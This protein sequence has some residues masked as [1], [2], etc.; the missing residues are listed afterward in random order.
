MPR[1]GELE[2][3]AP[4]TTC[5]GAFLTKRTF[6]AGFDRATADVT[7]QA[8][9][10]LRW[11]VVKLHTRVWPTELLARTLSEAQLTL[12]L[13][14][15]QGQ[16]YELDAPHTDH[17]LWW[18]DSSGPRLR[19]A[20]LSLF[21]A[22]KMNV[23]TT[24]IRADGTAAPHPPPTAW[25]P[26]L[27]FY[28]LAHLTDDPI[29]RFR[30][31]YLGIE[32]GISA[33]SPKGPSESESAWLKRVLRAQAIDCAAALQR[34]APN[35]VDP[36]DHLVDVVYTQTRLPAFHAKHG[37]HIFLP[38]DSS[39][40]LSAAATSEVALR[41]LKLIA[42][43]QGQALGGFVVAPGG[44]DLITQRLVD[45]ATICFSADTRKHDPAEEVFS[46]PAHAVTELVPEVTS[47]RFVRFMRATLS[48]P[49]APIA[50]VG[51]VADGTP[52]SATCYE[53]V[54]DPTGLANI[55]FVLGVH[56][57]Q[58]GIAWTALPPT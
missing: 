16:F 52:I 18:E 50:R 6:T 47:E 46:E 30:Y 31:L 57:T 8:R 13:F 12:D 11:V 41:L 19:A 32:N 7:V 1:L 27:R 49:T 55:Q 23:K 29:E 14:G 3:I 39:A 26:L 56:M 21:E 17:L 54:L 48:A 35:G 58:P 9:K 36:V 42:G 4:N 33:I 43:A 5:G 2:L 15:R 28:R 22:P 24:V 45:A 51:L 10:G 20:H 44:F 25:H 38:S 37:Q 40:V 53:A 34:P